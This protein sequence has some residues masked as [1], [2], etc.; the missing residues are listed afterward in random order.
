[1]ISASLGVRAVVLQE[2]QDLQD[3]L[4][5]EQEQVILQR[6]GVDPVSRDM[7]EGFNLGTQ[8]LLERA[9]RHIDTLK[10]L[11]DEL[12]ASA[13]EY[14][15]AETDIKSSFVPG[16]EPVAASKVT[17]VLL[18]AAGMGVDGDRSSP[19]T[20]DGLLTGGMR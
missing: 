15:H 10:A 5:N 18:Q 7:S 2:A 4:N 19:R 12:A 13:T 9:R 17:P 14:G 6:L 3:M 8:Q 16:L 11:G 1:M 20:I